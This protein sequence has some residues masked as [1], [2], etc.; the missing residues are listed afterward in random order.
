MDADVP[1]A[2]LA[3]CSLCQRRRCRGTRADLGRRACMVFRRLQPRSGEAL[4]GVLHSVERMPATV[5]RRDR[6]D[7]PDAPMITRADARC[8]AVVS[9]H[10]IMASIVAPKGAE[11]ESLL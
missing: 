5:C 7:H 8:S 9:S 11:L 3:L 6:R 1:G 10:A 4:A 2:A